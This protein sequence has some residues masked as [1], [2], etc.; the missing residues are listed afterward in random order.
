MQQSAADGVN[1][2]PV[3][4]T[5]ASPGFP[6]AIRAGSELFMLVTYNSPQAIDQG[7]GFGF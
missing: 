1:G 4:F 7:A 5:V 3:T 2:T 6:Y